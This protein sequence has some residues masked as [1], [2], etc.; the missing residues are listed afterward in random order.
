MISIFNRWA[1]KDSPDEKG[2]AQHRVKV[3]KIKE[4]IN[5]DTGREYSATG[6]IIKYISKNIDGHGVDND[7]KAAQDKDWNGKDP[8]ENA[9]RIE[10]WARTNRIR[11]FQPIGGPSVTVWRELRRLSEQEGVVEDIRQAAD[12][13]DWA[14]FVKAMGGP[15][16]PRD[17]YIARPTYALSE[18]LDFNSGEI[19][20]VTHTRYGDEARERVVGILIHGITV[21]S[22]THFWQIRENEKIINARQKIMDGIADI[23]E[24]VRDQNREFL[25]PPPNILSQQAKPAAL[26]LFQ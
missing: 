13:G 11:Q 15:N 14:A 8:I 12:S 4:G 5:P 19:S 16:I 23:L 6:Y 20:Q 9:E 21:L 1:L 18:K 10:A 7:E 26:D 17:Q 22:R 24:E 3:E 2:A 25:A